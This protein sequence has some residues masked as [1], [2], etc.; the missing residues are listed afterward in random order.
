[1]K[2]SRKLPDLFL[3]LVT[4]IAFFIYSQGHREVAIDMAI[5][6]LSVQQ[7]FNYFIRINNQ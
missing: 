7:G 6:S 4:G 5:W 3:L 2:E 1:M